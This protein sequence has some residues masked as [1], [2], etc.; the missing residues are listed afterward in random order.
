LLFFLGLVLVLL[1]FSNLQI[2]DPDTRKQL[3]TGE[4]GLLMVK[5]SLNMKEYWN[6]PDGMIG[7]RSMSIKLTR[8]SHDEDF[9]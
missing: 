6:K 8:S 4:R 2:I 1:G 5:T 9:N 7:R 3:S